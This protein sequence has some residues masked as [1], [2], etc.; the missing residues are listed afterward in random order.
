MCFHLKE[1]FFSFRVD[2]K[3]NALALLLAKV[4]AGVLKNVLVFFQFETILLLFGGC[5]V[6]L[7]KKPKVEPRNPVSAAAVLRTVPHTSLKPGS[8]FGY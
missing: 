7:G 3:H 8:I 1:I 5:L 4:P 2:K 6:V